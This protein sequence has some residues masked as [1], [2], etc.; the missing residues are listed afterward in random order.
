[1]LAIGLPSAVS[2]LSLLIDI[3][4]NE[5]AQSPGISFEALQRWIDAENICLLQT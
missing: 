3:T 5:S 1:M 2:F 4:Q